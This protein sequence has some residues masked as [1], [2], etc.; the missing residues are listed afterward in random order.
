[1]ADLPNSYSKIEHLAYLR[2]PAW[3]IILV[4]REQ[5]NRETYISQPLG[6]YVDARIARTTA[7][8]SPVCSRAMIRSCGE[9]STQ[10]VGRMTLEF[11]SNA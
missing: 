8:A 4:H 3:T 1:M 9:T 2:I 7:C 5:G 10:P 11:G 6:S